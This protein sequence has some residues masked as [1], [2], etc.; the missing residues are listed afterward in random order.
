MYCWLVW[1]WSVSGFKD[2][3][4]IVTVW[5]GQNVTSGQVKLETLRRVVLCYQ[6]SDDASGVEA[7]LVSSEVHTAHVKVRRTNWKVNLQCFVTLIQFPVQSCRATVA[8]TNLGTKDNNLIP[9]RETRIHNSQSSDL[10]AVSTRKG[11]P[12]GSLMASRWLVITVF[13]KNKNRQGTRE[14]QEAIF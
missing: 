8:L 5:L 10:N 7:E 11:Q 4:K 14:R 13:Q 6:S 12:L 1:L 9:E 3:T 2:A